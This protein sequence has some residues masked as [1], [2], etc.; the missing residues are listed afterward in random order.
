SVE[1]HNDF[2]TY[3][4]YRNAADDFV[5]QG[6][7]SAPY[8]KESLASLVVSA[9][10]TLSMSRISENCDTLEE[11]GLS[12]SDNPAYYTLT[13]SR[14]ITHTV[15]IGKPIPTGAGYYCKYENRPA[16]YVLDSTLAGTLLSDVRTLMTAVI[17][18]PMSTVYYSLCISD[19]EIQKD[20]ELFLS[21][22]SM[23]DA[24][25]T[26]TASNSGWK[27]LYPE[28]GYTPSA[29]NMGN[30]FSSFASLTGSAVLEYQVLG[31]AEEPTE[32]QLEV[33]AR[34]GLSKPYI[35]VTY[36]YTDPSGGFSV[37]NGVWFSARTENGTYYV[38]SWLFDLISEVSESDCPW[39]RYS[40]IDFID[41]PVFSRNIVDIAKISISSGPDDTDYSVNTD[42]QLVGDGSEL[43]V[44]DLVSGTIP[45]T[46]NFRHLY[47]TLLSLDIQGYAEDLSAREES[48]LATLRV[49]TEA[50]LVTVYRFYTESTRRCFVTIDGEGEFYVMRDA[51]R[52]MLS[53]TKKILN[54]EDVD[55]NS[56]S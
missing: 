46:S 17:T 55:Y 28:G 8:S 27:M 31:D 7:E 43:V 23:S 52:K 50:G 45:D 10:F 49:E 15:Y 13:T 4:F 6:A 30:L 11:Y 24:E 39:I 3:T 20:G 14:G 26:Q 56:R 1:V 25:K 21:V 9:G 2:G 35:S 32:E 51:V 19:L 18:Y 53:D 38:Y 5:I 54:G 16:V 36:T 29:T 34:Y 12:D 47:V 42:F 44:T 41:P 22:D 40:L 48:L 33:L 37:E